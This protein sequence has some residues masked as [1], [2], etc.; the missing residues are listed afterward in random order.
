MPDESVHLEKNGHCKVMESDVTKNGYNRNGH[1]AV[2]RRLKD[3]SASNR[4][5][6]VTEGRS[7]TEDSTSCNDVSENVHLSHIKVCLRHHSVIKEILIVII[8]SFIYR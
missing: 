7:T 4:S 6:S 5:S 2:V 8:F 1:C 3:T